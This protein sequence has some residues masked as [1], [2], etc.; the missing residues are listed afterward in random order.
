MLYIVLYYHTEN[1]NPLPIKPRSTCPVAK[2]VAQLICMVAWFQFSISQTVTAVK[3]LQ[4]CYYKSVPP[5]II[6]HHGRCA[7]AYPGWWCYRTLPPRCVRRYKT[8]GATP[9]SWGTGWT[10]PGGR[11]RD[12]PVRWESGALWR[13]VGCRPAA[14]RNYTANKQRF[15]QMQMTFIS[16]H[17]N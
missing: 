7:S 4:T 13:S 16:W 10:R 8:P 5:R 2:L 9:L 1:T 11:G 15:Q 6:K 14:P 17:S 12:D 3:F